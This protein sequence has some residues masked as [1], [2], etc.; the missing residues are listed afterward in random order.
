MPSGVRGNY[1]Q[2]VNMSDYRY[3]AERRNRGPSGC[4]IEITRC[5]WHT[6]PSG[7]FD[8]RYRPRPMG[9]NIAVGL[10][11]LVSVFRDGR[12]IFHERAR[13]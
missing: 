5:P 1:F 8:K 11:G 9:V 2:M 6:L 7:A 10:D 3:A 4:Y 13:R 12:R